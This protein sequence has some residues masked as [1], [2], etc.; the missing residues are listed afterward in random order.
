MLF[1]C[2][3]E[4]SPRL[5]STLGYAPLSF[6][7]EDANFSPRHRVLRGYL[8]ASPETLFVCQGPDASP[9]Q[10]SPDPQHYVA[11]RDDTHI[12]QSPTRRRSRTP[13][14]PVESPPN[15]M[16]ATS[17][18][19]ARPLVVKS[20]GSGTALGGPTTTLGYSLGL[21]RENPAAVAGPNTDVAFAFP[22]PRFLCL[23]PPFLR[24]GQSVRHAGV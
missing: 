18:P 6:V 12:A 8:P 10:L 14:S 9:W 13:I 3:N 16:M 4:Q 1:H 2:A 19:G 5:L 24:R 7:A 23:T 11:L 20:T 15:Q 21:Q 17:P 22:R